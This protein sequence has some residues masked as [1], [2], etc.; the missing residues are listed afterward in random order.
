MKINVIVNGAKGRMGQVTVNAIKNEPTLTLVSQANKGDNLNQLIKETHAQVVVDFT[1][2]SVAYEN[3]KKIIEAGAHPVIGSSGI[4]AEQVKTLQMLCAEKKLGG[5]IA[6]NFSIGATLMMQFAKLA[7]KY[8]PHVEIIELHHD[9]K[10]DAPSGTA[11]KTAEM[12]AEIKTQIQPKVK[13]T[14]ILK[15]ARGANYHDIKIH[16]IRLPGLFSH[17]EVIFGNLGE[18]LTLRLDAIDRQAM[19]P[20]VILACKKVITLNTLYYGL[21]HL[22]SF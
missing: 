10:V 20:G 12:I 22:L 19:M 7:S 16:S 2:A 14:E 11:I 9:Q 8:L 3:A 17:Q 21:E 4:T 6:P 18:T 1:P 15:G 13:E 5:V